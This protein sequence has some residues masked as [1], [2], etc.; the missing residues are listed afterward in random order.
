M[1][2][3][4]NLMG[5]DDAVDLNRGEVRPNALRLA[6]GRV[7]AGARSAAITWVDRGSAREIV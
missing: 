2:A 6:R 3:C 7:V 5:A 1:A 4:E